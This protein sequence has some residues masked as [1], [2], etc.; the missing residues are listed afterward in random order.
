MSSDWFTN[1][2]LSLLPG[3]ALPSVFVETGTYHGGNIPSKIGR[4]REIHSIDLS[5]A[6]VQAARERYPHPSVTFHHGDSGAVLDDLVDDWQE[7]VMFFLD[8]H[9]SGGETALGPDD[10]TPLL[11]ELRVLSRRKWADIIFVDDTRLLGKKS[12][13]GTAG[14]PDWPL[15]EFDWRDVTMSALLSAYGRECRVLA[16]ADI[17]DRLVLVPCVSRPR[18]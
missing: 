17:P 8:A 11:R 16:C 3:V 10:E 6:Y 14:C 1:T 2:C 13:S 5:L 7:P 15:T 9:W 18:G 4:F 12:F